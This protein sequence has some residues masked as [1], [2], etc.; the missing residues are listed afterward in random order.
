LSSGLGLVSTPNLTSTVAGLGQIYLS[1]TQN[2]ISTPDLVSTTAGLGQIYVSTLSLVST[3]AGLGETY[4]STVQAGTNITITGQPNNPIVNLAQDVSGITSLTVTDFISS[5]SVITHT[6]YAST[7]TVSTLY[8]TNL[9]PPVQ[10]GGG[11]PVPS[12]LSVS[13]IYY[14]TG[15]NLYMKDIDFPANQANITLIT[16]TP[17]NIPLTGINNE[18]PQVDLDIS[19]SLTVSQNASIVGSAA[20]GGN[21]AIGGDLSVYGTFYNPSDERIKTNIS[22]IDTAHCSKILKELQ[23]HTYNYTDEPVQPSTIGFIAQEVERIVPTAVK[24]GPYKGIEDFA[25]LNKDQIHLIHYGATQAL[26][27]RVDVLERTVELLRNMLDSVIA[28]SK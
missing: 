1:S 16:S 26:M 13:Y 7:I 5:M 17:T 10:G 9:D 24:R 2:L 19:G 27:E 15:F 20:F 8:Y 22:Y 25:T 14:S 11:G 21:V 4:V 3:V 12:T 23:L 6:L 28:R 18:N